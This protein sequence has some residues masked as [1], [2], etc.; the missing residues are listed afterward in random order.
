MNTNYRKFIIDFLFSALAFVYC[1]SFNDCVTR[2][3]VKLLGT[4][5]IFSQK[6]YCYVRVHNCFQLSVS[7]KYEELLSFDIT[8]T[9]EE[10]FVVRYN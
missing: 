1:F 9:S 5:N 6:L 7:H 3:D 2:T 10:T 8:L 4:Y